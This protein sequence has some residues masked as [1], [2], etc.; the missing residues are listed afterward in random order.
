[1]RG[2]DGAVEYLIAQVV[3]MTDQVRLRDRYR[4]LAENATDVVALADNDGVVQWVSDAVTRVVGWAPRTWRAAPGRT[5][6]TPTTSRTARGAGR[7]RAGE[8]VEMDSGCAG[9][10]RPPLGRAS[11][12][13]R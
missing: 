9:G 3:D 7:L 6:S 4:M 10:R 13:G 11:A 2:D 1:M 8:W 12:S 5:S